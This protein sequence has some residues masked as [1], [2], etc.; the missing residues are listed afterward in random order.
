MA[1]SRNLLGAIRL[2]NDAFKQNANT[3]VTTDIVML[4]KRLPGEL[5]QEPAWKNIAEITN[6]TGESIAVNEY[7]AER[8]EM[9]LGEMRLTGRMYRQGEPELVGLRQ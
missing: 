8:P 1:S 3:E 9:M 5:P 2:P 4:R 7:F 6:S